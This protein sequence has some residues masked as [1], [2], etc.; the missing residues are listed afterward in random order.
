MSFRIIDINPHKSSIELLNKYMDY[1]DKLHL[2][3]APKDPLPPKDLHLQRM[4]VERAGEVNIRK[5]V[6]FERD[7]EIVAAF[8]MKYYT[9]ESFE[10]EKNKHIVDIYISFL[11]EYKENEILKELLIIA[12]EVLKQNKHINTIETWTDFPRSWDFWEKLGAE[13]VHEE[14]V[15]RLYFDVANWNLMKEWVREGQLRAKKDKIE[16]L[17]FKECPEEII[18]NLAT[19]HN[20]IMKIVP[21]GNTDWNQSERTPKTI[22]ESEEKRREG[23]FGWQVLVT[24]ENDGTLSGLTEVFFSS[25]TPFWV[26]QLSTG[27]K[28]QYQGRGLGKWLKAAMLLHIKENL[29]KTTLMVTGNFE[30]NAPI[31]SINRRMGFK[32]HKIEK[33]FNIKIEELEKRL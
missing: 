1:T 21:S 28:P 18:K 12:L 9:E 30:H 11:K 15:S 26:S 7:D 22:R 17:K 10:F 31:M 14:A 6:L 2:E 23:G 27:V 5:A 4:K 13:V 20:D 33:C 29:P 24:K 25:D 16:L 8:H 32:L 19:L 3:H